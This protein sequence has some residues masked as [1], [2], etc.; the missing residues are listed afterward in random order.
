MSEQKAKDNDKSNITPS[1][2]LSNLPTPEEK[3]WQGEMSRAQAL[4]VAWTG[5]QPL[6]VNKQV[7]IFNDKK[8]G[9]VWFGIANAKI[10]RAQG[11]KAVR[12]VDNEQPTPSEAL[13]GGEK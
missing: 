7:I 4:A 6:A 11:N 8:T 13:A 10:V 3:R 12:L 2:Q 5:L 9:R 1:S